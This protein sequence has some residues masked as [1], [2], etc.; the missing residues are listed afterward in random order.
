[1][2]REEVIIKRIENLKG[3]LALTERRIEKEKETYKR[4]TDRI[5]LYKT[6]L[7]KLKKC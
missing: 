5:A 4:Q 7:E 1:M 3:Q 6:E 2:N